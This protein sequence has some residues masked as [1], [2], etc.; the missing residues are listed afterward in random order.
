MSVRETRGLLYHRH[1]V[2]LLHSNAY[3][4]LNPPSGTGHRSMKRSDV[5]RKDFIH[6]PNGQ[7]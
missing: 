7:M 3:L 2:Q 1:N 4:C 5:L 6:K